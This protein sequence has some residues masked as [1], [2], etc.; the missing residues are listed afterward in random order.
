MQHASAGRAVNG[1]C[2][3]HFSKQQLDAHHQ[4]GV[5]KMMPLLNALNKGALLSADLLR[6][7]PR[8]FVSEAKLLG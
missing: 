6:Y 5:R 4:A 1:A 8:V 7:P 3:W 2:H